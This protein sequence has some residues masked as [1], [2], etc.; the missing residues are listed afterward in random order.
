MA[1]LRDTRRASLKRRWPRWWNAISAWCIARRCA[2]ARP[3]AGAGNHPGG[4]HSPGEKSAQPARGNHLSAWLYR[5]ARFAASDA[6]KMAFRRQQREHQAVQMNT[7]S[8]TSSDESGWEQIAPLLDE[9]MAALGEKDRN[10]VMLRFF[11]QE[12]LE[13]VGVALGI[14]PRG[15]EAGVA[16]GGQAAPILSRHGVALSADAFTRRF[17]PTPF[18]ARP[19]AWPPSW[20]RPPHPK[21]PPPPPQPQPSSKEP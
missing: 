13:E 16:G 18:T 5:A 10:A 3:G 21:A 7:I 14:A 19:P 4:V 6:R 11:E 12:S 9:A 20:P 17:P 1:L 8:P 2:G 15:A